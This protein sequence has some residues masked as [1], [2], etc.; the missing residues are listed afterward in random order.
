MKLLTYNFLT[1]KCIRGVKVGY[2]LKLNVSL[3]LIQPNFKFKNLFTCFQIIEK[4]IEHQDFSAEFINRIL[5]RLDWPTI[6]VAAETVGYAQE[7]PAEINLETAAADTVLL[8]KIHHLLME[9]DVI[10]GHM[11]CPET[12]RVFPISQGIPNMLLNEDEV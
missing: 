7:L 9:I 4:K 6:K 2:P 1:S 11:S 8:Q 12:G 5:P 10:E 3:H